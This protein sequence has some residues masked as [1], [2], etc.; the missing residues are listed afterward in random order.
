MRARYLL[1]GSTALFAAPA[2]AADL[3]ARG[4]IY[5]APQ[6]QVDPWTGFYVGVNAG[7]A[8]GHSNTTTAV[9]CSVPPLPIGPFFGSYFCDATGFGAA[10][11]AAVN[12]AGSGTIHSSGFTGGVQAGH[13]WQADN[14]V[15]GLETD[16]SAFRLKG[17]AQGAGVYPVIG[18]GLLVPGTAFTVTPST[19][20]DWLFTFRGRIGWATPTLLFYATGGLAV[21]NLKVTGSFSDNSPPIGAIENAAVTKDKLGFAVG[22]GVEWALNRNWS[23]KG[24]YLFVGFGKVTASG[25]ITQTRT[26]VAYSQ[27]IS[28]TSDLSA[29][30]ARVGINY[31]F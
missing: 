15:Y 13:N 18:L 21:T 11:A 9:D 17:S 22:G 30:V 4:A 12:A 25:F 2:I 27:A 26:G 31:R 1:L 19:N 8:W 10:N 14:I 3:P 29:H 24:E 28:T 20:T 23:L 7:G 5:K 16:F 6:V